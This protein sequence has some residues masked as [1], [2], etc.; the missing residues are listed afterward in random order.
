MSD[1][2][3]PSIA[4]STSA[5]MATNTYALLLPSL[6][7]FDSDPLLSLRNFYASFGSIVVWAPIKAMG[8]VVIVW[9]REVDGRRA[10]RIAGQWEI[11]RGNGS[12]GE[13]SGDGKANDSGRRDPGHKR[14][15]SRGR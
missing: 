7:L 1:P 8:R 11:E 6:S 10:R 4:P 12:Q 9:D 14:T 3:Q 13:G 15:R 2:T 5:N